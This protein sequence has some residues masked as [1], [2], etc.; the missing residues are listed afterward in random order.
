[1]AFAQ[2]SEPPAAAAGGK[3]ASEMLSRV[4]SGAEPWNEAVLGPVLDANV[5]ALD[6]MMRATRVA[7]CHWGLEDELGPAAPVAHLPKARALSRLNTLAGLRAMSQGRSDA[8]VQRWLA[9]MRFARHID[10]GGPLISAMSGWAALRST[11]GAIQRTGGD[12][13]LSVAQR[14]QLRAAIEAMPDTVFDWVAALRSE[15]RSVDIL[16]TRL[17]KD[18]TAA[19]LF[20]NGQVPG[21]PALPAAADA[22][23]FA[24]YMDRVV[25]AVQRPPEQ[26]APILAGLDKE[27]AGLHGFFAAV[28]PSLTRINDNRR[29]VTLAR[30]R[31]LAALK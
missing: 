28:I 7:A 6:T 25:A 17:R 12:R 29:D 21:G 23:S 8:A 5:W 16:L 2:M 15:Q 18:P 10:G 26:A 14:T 22:A 4:E 31:T 19:D 9:G 27:K 13:A 20:F 11:W 24:R 3:D 30:E 1:M